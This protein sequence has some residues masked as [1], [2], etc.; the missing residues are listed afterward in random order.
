M[1]N[2]LL[3]AFK[4]SLAWCEV[5]GVQPPI[6]LM[7]RAVPVIKSLAFF[8]RTIERLVKSLYDG[9]IGGEFVDTLKNL[10][11]GQMRRAYE[12]AWIDDGNE[13][14]L[15]AYLEQAAA[16]LA[17]EQAGYVD[18]YYRAIVDARTDKTSIAPLMSRAE[19]WANRY[20]QAKSD[21][22]KAMALESGGKLEWV[23]GDTI[24][25]CD[26][27]LALNG[28][29]AYASEWEQSGFRPQ[30]APNHMID[31]GG[32]RCQCELRP[33]SKRKTPKALET[34][35]NIAMSRQ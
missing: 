18:G 8:S 26:T 2:E 16:E 6:D 11:R 29:V 5:N 35:L 27:C 25:K 34:L 23:E 7:V 33:T 15:P 32:W 19:L 30:N 9:Y 4:Y 13:L 20:N 12:E 24:E 17:D 14:P 31:C 21:A 3:L 28:I 22:V 1:D 10:I